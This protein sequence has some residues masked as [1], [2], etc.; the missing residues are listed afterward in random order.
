M[1][2]YWIVGIYR[3]SKDASTTSEYIYVVAENLNRANIIA[4]DYFETIKSIELTADSGPKADHPDIGILMID[5][6]NTKV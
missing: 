5:H 2:L 1:K 3:A 4:L 6:K